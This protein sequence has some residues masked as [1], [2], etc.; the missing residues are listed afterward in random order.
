MGTLSKFA[1]VVNYG[2][3]LFSDTL[4]SSI[5]MFMQTAFLNIGAFTNVVATT[6]TYPSGV[7]SHSADPS[8]LRPSRDPRYVSG[9]SW[10]GVRSDWVWESGVD[11]TSQP[12]QISGVYVNNV[13][14]PTSTSGVSG[15]K[16]NYP[17]GKIIFDNPISTNSTVKCSHSYRNVKIA[18]SDTNWFQSVQFDSFRGDDIQFAQKGSGT[19]DVLSINRVQLPAIVLESLPSVSMKPYELGSINRTHYQ[20]VFMHVLAETPWDRKQLHD[21]VCNQYQKRIVLINKKKLLQDNKYPLNFDGTLS[22]S[23]YNYEQII[24]NY[25][26]Q[27]ISW[28]RIRSKEVITA[29][30]L[31]GASLKVT[32][33]IDSL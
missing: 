11:Y 18:S 10:E 9:R 3:P 29:P 23:G 5:N 16:I 4:E 33:S 17:E 7:G 14:L 25:S 28:E 20:D 26:I 27:G 19:W 1:G 21:I 6:G 30:P 22:T 2:D 13:F 32:F 24:S 12:I 15:Y 31:F 8:K